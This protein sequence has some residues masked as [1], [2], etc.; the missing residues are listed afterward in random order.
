M[1]WWHHHHH[2][3][4]DE[5]DVVSTLY[6]IDPPC[7]PVVSLADMKAHL[8]VDY[9]DDNQLITDL[10]AAATEHLD[11]KEGILG[12]ALLEQTWELRMDRFPR[13]IRIPLPP[14]ISVD[15]VQ[16]L[17]SNA[18]RV[19]IDPSVYVVTGEGGRGVIHLVAGA[20]WP[21]VPLHH[22]ERAIVQ[23][24][25]GYEDG[26]PAPI[27]SAIKLLV[28]SLYQN[29]EHLVIGQTAIVLPWAVEALLQRYVVQGA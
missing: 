10:T 15:K 9:S 16:Y 29:R 8:R 11:G 13:E 18:S 2:H 25:A 19:T 17:D 24:T 6:L 26:V 22:P 28:G 5:R 3:H 23:F 7:A 27:K 1:N 12:R 14:L 21:V 4:G 20:C